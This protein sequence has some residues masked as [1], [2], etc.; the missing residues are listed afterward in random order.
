MWL[1]SMAKQKKFNITGI[2]I[3][4]L[5]YMVDT[6]DK[7]DKII[8]DY[9]ECD[10]YFTINRARQYGKSTTLEMLYNRLKTDYLVLDISF[11]AAEDCFA[12]VYTMV[13][14]VVNKVARALLEY[15]VPDALTEIW[16]S[17][18]STELPLDSLSTKI[19]SFCKA[20][21]KEV[22]L[23]VD[24]VDKAADNQIFLSFLGLLREKYLKRSVGRDYTFKSVILAGVHDIK[25]LK[26]KIHPEQMGHYNSPWNIAADF[27]IDMSFQVSG[28][29]SMLMEYERDKQTGMD[30]PAI[31]ELIYEYT[32]G[33]PFL[34]SYICKLLDERNF[35]WTREGIQ[36]AVKILV[37]G[38]NTLYDDMIKQVEEY[39]EMSAMLKNIL[40]RGIEYPYNEYNKVIN[41]GKMLGF[42]EDREEVTAVSY[43]RCSCT[44]ISFPKN[45]PEG[46][47]RMVS[48][49]S[50]Y[51]QEDAKFVEEHGRKIFL[52]YLKPNRLLMESVISMLKHRRDKNENGYCS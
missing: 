25:N 45:I 30:V 36:E 52:I 20:S 2:C 4:K 37:K 51:R 24:E 46:R 12:S 50:L 27:Q 44:V 21:E 7:V 9:I 39:P 5:H 32:S 18:V 49:N 38:P 41:I 48:Y 15:D 11:E 17:P 31:S 23:M 19:T 13:L 35:A 29:E 34:V 16:N 43:L 6:G 3:P 28:I 22:I 8:G 42:I 33:Y 47:F 1:E 14:G 26:M 40:F 10:E